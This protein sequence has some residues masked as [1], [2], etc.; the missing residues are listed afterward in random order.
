MVVVD[1]DGARRHIP[2]GACW[3]DRYSAVAEI[4]TVHWSERGI[5]NNAQLS[6]EDLRGY[7]LGC[8]VQ[9]V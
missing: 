7:V 4:C 5:D 9:Y 3:I 2:A 8:I 6:A 1:G